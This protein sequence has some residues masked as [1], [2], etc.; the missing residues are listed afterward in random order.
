MISIV[1][2]DVTGDAVM[3][4]TSR[5]IHAFARQFSRVRHASC[6]TN[7]MKTTIGQLVATLFAKH[8]R[9]FHNTELAALATQVELENLT[10]VQRMRSASSTRSNAWERS[11]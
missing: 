10:G 1:E 9:C 2:D 11:S 6:T 3:S 8:E 4:E 7:G 5:Y